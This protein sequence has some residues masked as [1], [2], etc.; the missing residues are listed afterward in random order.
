MT[1][2]K[3]KQDI[4]A[5]Q[6]LGEVVVITNQLGHCV[7]VTRQD[8]EG[9]ILSV[10]W[11]AKPQVKQTPVVW[12][13][14]VEGEDAPRLYVYEPLPAHNIKQATPLYPHPQV[15][16]ESL[17]VKYASDED[18]RRLLYGFMLDCNYVG[19]DQ[20]AKNLHKMMKQLVNRI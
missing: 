15:R 20:A 12:L 4:I 2:S 8:D 11:E 1:Q 6:P 7:A 5:K 19:L 17:N 3:S 18:C 13:V 10:I 14:E 16:L 9:R